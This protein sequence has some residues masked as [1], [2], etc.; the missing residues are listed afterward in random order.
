[1]DPSV[2]VMVMGGAPLVLALARTLGPWLAASVPWA[3]IGVWAARGA[4]AL[5]LAATVVLAWARRRFRGAFD[6]AAVGFFHPFTVDGG[7]GERVLWAAVQ[8][9]QELTDARVRCV[10]YTGDGPEDGA[11]PEALRAR[12]L[13]R[14]N[15]R[16]ARPVE[17]V[18]LSRRGLVEAARYP[19]L[20]VL[21]Q[22]L[23][24]AALALEGA[25]A[26]CPALWVDTSGYPL[27]YPFLRLLCGRTRIA[28]Y[29][30]YPLVSS[31]MA[32][33][34][35]RGADMYNNSGRIAA[36]A[37]L[38]RL[39]LMY[40][41]AMMAVYG[42]SLRSAHLVVANSTWTAGHLRKVAYAFTPERVEVVFPP[43]DTAGLS[44]V[45][46]QPRPRR[47]LVSVGQFRPEKNHALLIRAL[48][49]ACRALKQ[50]GEADDKL[51]TL[52]LVG[53]VRNDADRRRVDDLKL[54]A[55]REV[56]KF[57]GELVRFVVD[58]PFAEVQ[59]QL[60][61]ST[62]G[63]HAMEDEHFG[64]CVVEYMAAG[65]IPLAHDSGGPRSDI[66]RPWAPLSH[67][68]PGG[69]TGF[70]ATTADQYASK[71]LHAVDE[72]ELS[73]ADLLHMQRTARLASTTRFSDA[74]FLKEL[75]DLLV[76][77]NLLPDDG[78]A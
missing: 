19:H 76:L 39:K 64:M 34:V 4:S 52:A 13:G 42:A 50:R 40:Y 3:S 23:G 25:A 1:M 46:L 47:A 2:G 58:A 43:C 57:E 5:F 63:L 70:L 31:D 51:P 62:L 24:G 78:R 28:A 32:D 29:V 56:G 17:L 26:V 68:D 55:D 36:S 14:F 11:T 8:A 38:T 69:P 44:R 27:A 77:H 74:R 10:V 60:A 45:P 16:L 20:T 7:G 37:V 30:H 73:D 22:S 35:R 6:G 54:L 53:G 33:R 67:G 12:A 21:G 75:K 72:A 61:G 71:I 66:V 41:G 59:R 48:G 15:V 9:V 65:C 18:R 49:I